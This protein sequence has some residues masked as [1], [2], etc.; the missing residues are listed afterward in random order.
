M[1]RCYIYLSDRYTSGC[2]SWSLPLVIG[3]ALLSLLT[4][5][6]HYLIFQDLYHIGIYFVGDV[7]FL[8]VE[9]LLVYLVIDELLER[10]ERQARLSKLESLIAIFFSE[11]GMEL[12]AHLFRMDKK[13]ICLEP[14]MVT[15]EE[16]K[17]ENFS[18]AIQRCDTMDLELEPDQKDLRALQSF[19]MSKRP[20]LVRL[21][22]N[23][24]LM[25]HEL[26]TDLLQAILHL[27]EELE[28]RDRV[29]RPTTEELEHL[30]S[31]CQRIYRLLLM[32]WYE[33]LHHLKDNYPYLYSLAVRVNPL[34]PHPDAALEEQG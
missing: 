9:A 14:D 17:E 19:L 28:Y 5:I 1:V 6:V 10:K 34:A 23:P 26:F 29:K 3:L 18:E 8:F 25:E 16:W 32:E 11:A 21:M 22:E 30:S 12:L 13:G 31:D 4:Y 7:A 20:G 2:D 15:R 27:N 24:V 33:H